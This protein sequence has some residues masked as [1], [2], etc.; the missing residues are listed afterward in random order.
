[1]SKRR[2]FSILSIVAVVA[3]LVSACGAPATQ[4]P[5][6]EAPKAPAATAA[7]A[8]AK[9]EATK[10]PAAAAAPA[11]A[12]APAGG[13]AVAPA[14]EF[15]VVKDKITMKVFM[16]P[17]TAVSDYVNNE[18]TKWLEAQTN[19][20]L[21]F[22]LPPVADAQNKLNLMLASDDLSEVIIGCNIR[23]DQMQ[24]L[25]EQGV[26]LPLN[27][28]ID[29][30][31]VETKNMFKTDPAVKDLITLLDGK[32]YGLPHYNDCYHCSMSQKMWVYKPWLDKLGLKVPETTA[33]FEA[34]LKAFKEKDPNGN[35]KADEIPLSGSKLVGGGWHSPIDQFL[36]NSFVY[37][38][39]VTPNGA[40]HLTL[41]NGTVKAAFTEQGWKE[42]LK[43]LANLYKQG[44]IDPQ[45]F[46]ND[47]PTI[48]QL[49]EAKEPILGAIGAGW[50]GVFTQNGGPSGRWKE[51]LP[52]PPLKGPSGMRQ[53]PKTIF[54]PTGGQ[55]NC[56]ITKKAKNPEAAFR[57]CDLFYGFDSTTR[58]V[59]GVEGED[60][61][62]GKPGEET[63][64]PGGE[65][66]YNVL[67]VWGGDPHNR[68]WMQTA[69]TFRTNDYR[70]FNQ[71]YNPKDPLERSLYLWTKDL[72]EPYATKD[73]G[74]PPLVFTKD[75]SKQFGE[76]NT[77]VYSAF[78]EWFAN[79]VTGKKDVDKDWD[80]YVKNL[81]DS[82]L[83]KFLGIYQ[84][85][86]DAKYKKK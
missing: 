64:A 80:A 36:M 51:Y 65:P 22:D 69:P 57:M 73:K 35:G 40:R 8:A 60:W 44:L 47:S 5:K 16:C 19:I 12:K 1:M 41:D 52:I 81:K 38:D 66:K 10:A 25:A 13:V 70:L 83:D 54:Q 18:F 84:T 42:G 61:V 24:I 29:K 76:L 11:A 23:L 82:G 53:T 14:G 39:Q 7:P 6:A 79:F 62:R 17:N 78:D 55:G 4:A 58:S 68:N 26:A 37:N 48:Q 74:V 33:E 32:I 43:Y 28:Y 50:Y 30:Y 15:P 49:G 2:L 67:K 85:A 46:T 3:M 45:A 21:E 63:I 75:Q 31:G 20:K 27:D 71:V 72:M 86:Y 77:T 59:F 56:V 34:M 9:A